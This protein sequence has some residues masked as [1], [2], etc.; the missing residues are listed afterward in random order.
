MAEKKYGAAIGILIVWLLILSAVAGNQLINPIQGE[1]GL[2]GLK[3]DAGSQGSKG[4]KGDTGAQG[5]K[6]DKGDTG[7][8]GPAGPSGGTGATGPRGPAGESC[9]CNE[10]PIITLNNISGYIEKV[11]YHY[12]HYY[13]SIN[14]SIY[15]PEG[16]FWIV[17][18]YYRMNDSECKNWEFIKHFIGYQDWYILEYDTYIHSYSPP[19]KTIEWAIEVDDGLNLAIALPIYQ[20]CLPEE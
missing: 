8:T 12:W 4:E 11:G 18:V 19:C 17:D 5:P 3:G 6:G 20:V 13:Y 7:A 10:T 15:D 9:E 16:D 2:Q 14:F 1:Q